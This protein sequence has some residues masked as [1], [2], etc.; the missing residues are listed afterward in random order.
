M[1]M[2]SAPVS[3]AW[4]P[5]VTSMSAPTCPVVTTRPLWGNIRPETTLSSVDL[6]APFAPTMPTASPGSMSKQ[7][8]RSTQRQLLLWA[9]RADLVPRA[10]HVVAQQPTASVYVE[11]LPDAIDLDGPVTRHQRS[12]SRGA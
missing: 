8:S 1:L 4:M 5:A 7:M 2:F 10:A 12:R 3:S 9:R 11:S 6:P